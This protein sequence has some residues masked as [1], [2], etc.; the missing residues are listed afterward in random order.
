MIEDPDRWAPA[1]AEAGA[2]P[3]TFHVEAADAPV[4]LARELRAKGAR[5]GMA[6]KPATPVEPY[7]DLLRRARHAAADDRRA[8][9]RRPEVP[10][11]R[12]AEDP[13]AP[14]SWSRAATSTCGSRSTAASRRDHRALRRGRSR[15]VRRRLRGLWRGGRRRGRHGAARD[16]D[17]SHR[18]RL[19]GAAL[20]RVVVLAARGR[21]A[22]RGRRAGPAYRPAVF[23]PLD[24]T[25]GSPAGPLP[26]DDVWPG[27]TAAP[28]CGTRLGRGRQST[29]PPSTR[30]AA[31]RRDR[32]RARDTT[33]AMPGERGGP[34]RS[35]G[36]V[37]EVAPAARSRS[38]PSAALRVGAF[39][40]PPSPAGGTAWRPWRPTSPWCACVA[41]ARRGSPWPAGERRAPCAGVRRQT[42]PR[43]TPPGSLDLGLRLKR[44][45]SC[46]QPHAS[47]TLPAHILAASSSATSTTAKP[48][49][50]SLVST[51]A[52][53]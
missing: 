46:G 27:G 20:R 23:V 53:Q 34:S 17:P 13:A 16:R 7:A 52:R 51:R 29:R 30:A 42:A 36:A 18:R 43:R 5:A 40:N 22:D 9:L 11:P 25:T 35:G 14:A 45:T 41:D 24:E 15:R 39:P 19:V 31:V 37:S 1:Y 12:A 10:R 28:G 47:A 2:R 26:P 49:K 4:R 33:L 48:P 3:V 8:R 50:N 21:Q 32:G 6:L 38:T 44:R